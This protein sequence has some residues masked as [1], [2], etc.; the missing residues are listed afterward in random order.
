M[1][2]DGSFCFNYLLLKLLERFCLFFFL[3][4]KELMYEQSLNKL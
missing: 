4:R 2:F 3:E 1:Q